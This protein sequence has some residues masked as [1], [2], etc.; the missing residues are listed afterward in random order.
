MGNVMKLREGNAEMIEAA[1]QMLREAPTQALE[2]IQ[3]DCACAVHDKPYTVEFAREIDG[4]LRYLRSVKEG[5]GEGLASTQR[6]KR[7]GRHALA[8]GEFERM[9]FPCPWCGNRD[10]NYCRSDCGALVCG[11]RTQGGRFHCRPSCGA[12]WVGVPMTEISGRI[13]SP[14]ARGPSMSPP[15]EPKVS[16]EMQKRLLLGSGNALAKRKS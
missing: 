16:P 8:I 3:F 15:R 13:G 12:S 9:A 5:D 7:N 2:V 10:I 4:Q 14:P 1:L 11:G 6:E